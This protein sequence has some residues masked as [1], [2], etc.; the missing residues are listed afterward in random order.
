MSGSRTAF[1]EASKDRRPSLLVEFYDFLKESK[2]WWLLPILLVLA[3][4]GVL[5]FLGGSGAAP[6]LYTVF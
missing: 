3:L 1:E 6:F 2:K 5:V 4:L